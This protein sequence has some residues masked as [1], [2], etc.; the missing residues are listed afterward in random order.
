M[1]LLHSPV[2]AAIGL[3]SLAVWVPIGLLTFGITRKMRP[4]TL[5]GMMQNWND[6]AMK[7][8]WAMARAMMGM[9]RFCELL[10]NFMTPPPQRVMDLIISFMRSQVSWPWRAVVC[11]GIGKVGR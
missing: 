2:L 10:P 9:Y 8:P 1:S 5:K 4:R 6:G 7:A 11:C 3:F